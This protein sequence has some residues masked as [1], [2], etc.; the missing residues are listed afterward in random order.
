MQMRRFPIPI[1]D[2]E[3]AEIE[4]FMEKCLLGAGP[5]GTCVV[6]LGK[7]ERFYYGG[8]M[9]RPA[10]FWWKLVYGSINP[11]ENLM[12]TCDTPGCLR[13]RKLSTGAYAA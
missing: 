1:P 2:P 6:W 13:H 9:V 7:T 4:R 11:R 10:R 3:P 5:S 8:T 12:P